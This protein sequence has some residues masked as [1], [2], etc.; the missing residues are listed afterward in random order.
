MQ[1]NNNKRTL[2]TPR[3][4]QSSC[5]IV[6]FFFNRLQT[7]SQL[8]CLDEKLTEQCS[9]GYMRP[10]EASNFNPS[11]RGWLTHTPRKYLFL[12]SGISFSATSFFDTKK[13]GSIF[14]KI[15]LFE[16]VKARDS[17][18]SDLFHEEYW[19]TRRHSAPHPPKKE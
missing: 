15:T 1:A 3:T 11:L 9:H 2:Y 16:I 17:F 10:P 7:N 8:R 4:G 6:Y 12:L 13:K 19:L 14:W 18:I 5:E